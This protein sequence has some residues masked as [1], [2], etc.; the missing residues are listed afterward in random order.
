MGNITAEES[1]MENVMNSQ[2]IQNNRLMM[3]LEPL[4]EKK[5][6]DEN[7][8]STI[9]KSASES[10]STIEEGIVDSNDYQAE[11]IPNLSNH[12]DASIVT[13]ADSK[14]ENLPQ[15]IMLFADEPIIEFSAP[16][17]PEDDTTT[18]ITNARNIRK[19]SKIHGNRFLFR[20][21]TVKQH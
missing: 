13:S 3:N 8:S 4:N 12:V 5:L 16:A 6:F 15:K 14:S 2:E 21:D 19:R 20:A 17:K 18:L 7:Y 10:E 11:L 9:D 1:L